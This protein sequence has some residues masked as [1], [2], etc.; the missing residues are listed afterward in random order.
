MPFTRRADAI[1]APMMPV[2]S[3]CDQTRQSSL[4]P[5]ADAAAP[6]GQ[7][8]TLLVTRA[9]MTVGASFSMPRLLP[10]CRPRESCTTTSVTCFHITA[11][12]LVNGRQRSISARQ[13]RAIYGDDRR[14]S[15]L[16][17]LFPLTTRR[18]PRRRRHDFSDF[19]EANDS[20]SPL[21]RAAA[22]TLVY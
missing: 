12:C 18:R 8:A 14:G 13:P 21:S 11:R 20:A 22:F 6:M 2:I 15:A 16:M 9:L 7:G 3:R 10:T 1:E 17:R 5:P 4:A 19:T